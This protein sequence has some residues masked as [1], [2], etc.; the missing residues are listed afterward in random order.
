MLRGGSREL[1]DG[2]DGRYSRAR[3]AI[4]KA[5]GTCQQP[6]APK[7]EPW[8]F[9]NGPEKLKVRSKD[10]GTFGVAELYPTGYTVFYSTDPDDWKDLTFAELADQFEQLDGTPCGTVK[11]SDWPKY[12]TNATGFICD[13][14]L[15]RYDKQDG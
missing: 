8:T 2:S 14:M 3:V 10:D 1:M 13:T 15:V 7:V 5:E 6:E 12:Y 9:E 11:A 4:A